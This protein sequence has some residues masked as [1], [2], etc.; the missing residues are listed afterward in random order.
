MVAVYA[1]RDLEGAGPSVVQLS[2]NG[3]KLGAEYD[4]WAETNVY[5]QRQAGY[6]TVTVT[7]PLGDAS[8]EQ[9]RRLACC[10]SR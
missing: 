1:G 10:R 2:V 4:R 7:L 3:K 5:R 8:A 9:T 6:A